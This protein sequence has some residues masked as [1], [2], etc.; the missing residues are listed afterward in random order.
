M[1]HTN[2]KCLGCGGELNFSPNTQTLVCKNCQKQ[3]KINSKKGI[4]KV[5]YSKQSQQETKQSSTTTINCQSCGAKLTIKTNDYS[6]ICPY[7]N[8]NFVNNTSTI[9]GL[10]PNSIIPF[11]FDKEKAIEY[12]KAGVKKKFFLPNSFKKSPALDK[13]TGTYI[14]CFSFDA[15]THSHFDGK[16]SIERKRQIQGRQETYYETKLISGDRNYIF[17]DI[18]IESSQHTL[19]QSFDQIKPFFLDD[20]LVY[21]YNE[22]FLRGYVVQRHDNTLQNCK[23]LS[24]HYINNNIR[25][26][27]LSSYNYSYVNYL[28]VN[29]KFF[30]EKYSYLL[31]PVY[32]VNFKYKKKDYTTYINGQT[33]KIGDDLPKSK[34]KIFL[35]I[36][37]AILIFALIICTLIFSH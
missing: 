9:T 22:D 33:G 31:L 20:A 16:I 6:G 24:E 15:D 10:K 30:N 7:C 14:P 12:Y 36:L 13:I 26:R 27:I 8:S 2:T 5:D 18:I 17:N 32:F 34:L 37:P 4:I 1:Q 25:S 35:T 11:N 21:N 19:Q 3:Q 29:T 28:N 23:V